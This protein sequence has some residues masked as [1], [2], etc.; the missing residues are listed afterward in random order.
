MEI[1]VKP[2]MD[3]PIG[4]LGP[5]TFTIPKVLGASPKIL[6]KRSSKNVWA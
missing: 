5:T 1:A 6:Q 4:P 2:D 3:L